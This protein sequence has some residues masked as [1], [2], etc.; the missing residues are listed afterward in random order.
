MLNVVPT[1][2]TKAQMLKN[3][4]FN[5]HKFNEN[6]NKLSTLNNEGVNLVNTASLITSAQNDLNSDDNK[7]YAVQ[8]NNVTSNLYQQNLMNTEE[9]EMNFQAELERHLLSNYPDDNR[10][11]DRFFSNEPAQTSN[12][13]SLN[14]Y[15]SN[16]NNFTSNYNNTQLQS[17]ENNS[18][19]SVNE[20]YLNNS[21]DSQRKLPFD[22]FQIP[23][24]VSSF[25]NNHLRR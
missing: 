25:K 4:G 10:H 15:K 14:N 11:N 22:N 3:G 8:F 2:N 24:T 13:E 5:N 19:T 23:E 9:N 20:Q 21:W 12:F 17:T 16:Y 7:P 1:I 6:K 18:S